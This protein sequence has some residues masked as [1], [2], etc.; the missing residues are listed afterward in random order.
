M[1]I[2]ASKPRTSAE[3]EFIHS[4]E[5]EIIVFVILVTFF[6]FFGCWFY[7]RRTSRKS[8]RNFDDKVQKLM[9]QIRKAN[10]HREPPIV[11]TQLETFPSFGSSDLFSLV[12]GRTSNESSGE[13]ATENLSPS[14]QIPDNRHFHPIAVL[15]ST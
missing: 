12:S 10:V 3:I 14:P 8:I 6:A 2:A 9:A 4:I 1:A 15:K 5:I 13:I 11:S 7:F